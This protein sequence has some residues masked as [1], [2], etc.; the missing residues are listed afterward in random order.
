V[1]FKLWT[2]AGFGVQANLVPLSKRVGKSW[3]I[4][5]EVNDL[6]CIA[7]GFHDQYSSRWTAV[8]LSV[9]RLE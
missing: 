7:N 6:R 4:E 2:A 5:R 9:S 3:G 1:K 8:M